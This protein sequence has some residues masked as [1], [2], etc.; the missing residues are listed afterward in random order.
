MSGHKFLMKI[1]AARLLHYLILLLV[2]CLCAAQAQAQESKPTE[3]SLDD[4]EV[5]RVKT[6]LVNIDV[7][8]KDKKGKY[9]TGLKA[10]DFTIFE[11]GVQQKVAFFDPPLTGNDEAGQPDDSAQTEA[12]ARDGAPRN[13][14]SLVFDGQTTE[15]ANQKRVRAGIIKYIQEQIADT[16][17][18]ALFAVTNGLQLL[19]PFTQD[20]TKLI[21]AV[22]KAETI[23]TS[24]KNF[25]QRD[26]AGNI[27]QLRERLKGMDE[28]STG[29]ITT[30]A[31]GSAAAQAM[32]AN[33]VLQQFYVL[34]AQ[35]SLQQSRPILAALAAICEGQ[36]AVPGKKTL[37][38]FS[39][40]FITP[41]LL[42]WQVQSAIDIANRANVA[43]YIIDSAGLRADAPQSGGFTPTSPLAG[44]SGIESQ[45]NRIRA[46][47]GETVFDRA[48]Q[49]GL[50]REYDIL[51][52]ISGDTGGQFIK[53]TNDIAKG[54]DRMDQEIRSR[55]T[56]GYYSTDQN[57][58]GQFRKVKLEV[59][60]S[61]AQVIS[62]EGYYAVP[63]DE[64][65]PFSPD[66]RKLLASVAG[67]VAAPALP[68]FME[69]SAFRLGEG[70][71]VV[72]LS[73]ELPPGA[74]KFEQ[75]GERRRMQLE[76]LGVVR[77]TEDK[78]LSRLGGN[79]DVGL[80]AA[81]YQSILNDNIF[82][83]QDV[84]LSPGAYSID[85]IVRDKLSGKMAARREKLVLPEADTGFE[86]SGVTLSRHVEPLKNAAAAGD[87]YSQGGVQIRP[88]PSR[89]FR[90]T[91]N[92]II[93]FELYNAATS[94]GTGKPQV[95]V[96]VTLMKDDKAATK[97]VAYELT[98]TQSEPVPHLT[99][100]KYI[101]L[102]GLPLGKY[103][104]MIEAT[105]KVTRKLVK[106]QAAFVIVR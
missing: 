39:Q 58:D 36:R 25:E 53:G 51:Y 19:Q 82:Y 69:L 85:L 61:G 86:M 72:P 68:L 59:S 67:A 81:Q 8:V 98:E 35:L 46:V 97:P 55:Y 11:N 74:I 66:D 96:T 13:I 6:Q 105:D 45:E 77:Q 10:E 80:T 102:A 89:E 64:V 43:I 30:A 95:V 34:R 62:R 7:M 3:K 17:T 48:R 47:G 9:V 12:V 100:A 14:I 26:I 88:S 60:R 94:A 21:A 32:V 20:K 65:V 78:I 2:V 101:S 40:G 106:R 5:I 28:A 71:Y 84:E 4:D 91:D 63:H 44:I 37:V 33:R 31:G 90:L 50:N 79:F 70:R 76:V 22:E 52:R 83:R 23:S 27:D 57:F 18:V 75:K 49:E 38:L 29:S 42:D 41:G 56:V 93:F 15:Q 54:L 87:V 1:R 104:A 16:D 73:M 24:S 99:F 92:L 103:T